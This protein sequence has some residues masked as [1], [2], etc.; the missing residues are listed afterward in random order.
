MGLELLPPGALLVLL[1]PLLALLRG[2]ALQVGLVALPLLSFAHLLLGFELGDVATVSVYG[3]ELQPV[4]FDRLSR[5]WGIVFHLAA[6]ITAIF[7][8]GVKDRV[9]HVAAL[10]YAGAAICAAF[11]GDLVTLFVWWELTAVTSVFLVWASGT[12]EA[13]RAGLRYL[14]VQVLSGVLL[15]AGVLVR[16]HAGLGL[17]FGH[18]GLTGSADTTLILLAF[19]IKAGFPLLHPWLQDAYPKATVTGTVWMSSF[20]TKLAIYALARGYAGTELLIPIGAAMTLFPIFYAVIVNDLRTVLTYSLNNQLGYMVVGVGLGTELALNGTAA[21]AFAHILY[22]SLLF[23]GMGA[24]L[25]RTG[26]AKGSELGG[27]Y[28]TMPRT[29]VLTMVGAA[30]ISGF[31][32]TSGFISK[33]MIV[34]AAGEEGWRLTY[35]ALLFASAGVFHHSGIKIPYFAFFAHDSGKRPAEAP[36]HMQVAMALGAAACLILGCM[37]WLLYDLLPF[38]SSYVPYTMDH[39][40]TMLQLLLGSALAFALL[41]RIGAYPPELRST[42][43]DVDWVWRRLLPRSLAFVGRTVGVVGAFLRGAL[44]GTRDRVVDWVFQRTG[45]GSRWARTWDTGTSTLSVALLLTLYALLYFQ[46]GD[47]DP[48]VEHGGGH[49]VEPSHADDH[50]PPADPG[51][52]P[53]GH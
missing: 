21:H 40:V 14:V 16:H 34:S 3:L 1:A 20:T 4:R 6:V 7:S 51:H 42:V 44:F 30:A 11:A 49:G 41:N 8:L 19:G 45:P 18:L 37:P 46:L 24:V 9:Q 47:A 15:L 17:A 23:M 31:P 13:Y 52:A 10:A 28:K 38:P 29:A 12:E 35:L 22:K 25:L 5:I 27:L 50:A 43:L 53:S 33:S 32:L 2:R 26:T 48:L 39:V 36:V